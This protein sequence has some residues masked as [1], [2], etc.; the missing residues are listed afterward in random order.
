M[1]N[2]LLLFGLLVIHFQ[3]AN[4]QQISEQLA[5]TIAKNV[6][7]EVSL[8]N[9]VTD[10]VFFDDIVKSTDSK[11][12]PAIFIFNEKDGGFVIVSADKRAYPILA[13]STSSFVQNDT[14]EWSPSFRAWLKM[15]SLQIDAM[16]RENYKVEESNS[17]LWLQLE[18]GKSIFTKSSK[19]VSPLLV[20]T[21]NQGC[22]YNAL[23]P[24]ASGGPCGR[25]Y[26]GC[27]ATAM[28]QVM[29]HM[30]HPSTGIG[31]QCYTTSNY[32]ELC[33]NFADGTY[34]YALMTNG[35]GNSHV[36]KLMYHCGVS[37]YM[38]YSPSGSGAYSHSV[39]N[40][41]K[42]FFD[43][44]NALLV[45]KGN[46]TE[47]NWTRIIRNEIDNSRPIYYAGFGGSSGHAFV[48]DG[49]QNTTH[50]HINWGWGGA[51]NGYFY[52]SSLNPGGYSYTNGQQAIVGAIPTASFTNLNVSSA[53][54]LT[55]ATPVSGNISLGVDY[56]NYYKN[57]YPSAVGKELVYT[58]TT[59]LPGRIR[60]KVSNNVGG[61]VNV[62]LLSHPHQDSLIASGLN[63]VIVDN[64]IAKT[65]Y[66][67]VEGSNGTQPTF[68]IEVI[69]P[70]IDADL[71][72]TNSN[73]APQFIESF[74]GNVMF[75]STLKNIGN[76]NAGSCS[77]KY[78]LSDDLTLDGSDTFLGSDI[79]PAIPIGA[80]Q[81]IATNL[82]MPGGLVSGSYN[83][84]F[85]ADNENVVVESDDDNFAFAYVQVP[86]TGIMSC[87]ASVNL[88][89]GV[90]H[91]GNTQADGNS[92]I[93]QYWSASDMTGP[94][95]I[96]SFTPLFDGFTKVTFSEKNAGTINAIVLPICN[97]NTYLT[98]IWFSN[99]T[100]TIGYAE[101]YATAGTEY[102]IVVDGYKGEF[103]NYALKV[104]YPKECP[105]V[106]LQISG[107]T[108]LCDGQS[109]PSMWTAWGGSNYQWY[110]NGL[111]IPTETSSWF[112]P[113]T[114]GSYHIEITENGC[115]GS[116]DTI[117]VEMSFQPDTAQITTTDN[118]EFCIGGSA[119]LSL[120]N[121]VS[122]P[123][124]WAINGTLIPG[125]T[126]ENYVASQ[127]GNYTLATTNG[128]CTVQS[129]NSIE[130][131]T[132]QLPSNIGEKLP[133]PSENIK[134]Y[135]TFEKDNSDYSG[136]NFTFSCWNFQPT[137]DRFNNFWQARYFTNENVFGY[138]P[139]YHTIPNEFTLTLWFK[140]SSTS[141]GVIA[142]FVN[143]PWNASQME[144]MLYMSNNGKLHFYITNAGTPAELVSTFSYNDNQWHSVTIQFN[145]Q[146]KMTI[147]NGDEL[148]ENLN[149]ITKLNVTG[150]WV[151]AGPN[152]PAN[153]VDMPSSKYFDGSI[154]DML[155]VYETNN[156]IDKYNYSLPKLGIQILSNEINCNSALLE[157]EIENSELDTQYRIWNE[158]NAEWH[159][160]A[161]SGN[162]GNITIT[163]NSS[164]N[165]TT[166]FK[167]LAKN[168]ITNCEV[169]LD[170]TITITVNQPTAITTQPLAQAICEGDSYTFSILAEGSNLMYQW[171]KG[172][173]NI[174]TNSPS[175]I[176][177]NASLTDAGNYTCTV[178]GSCGEETSQIAE[179][180]VTTST[181]IMSE[182]IG[183]II[184]VGTNFVLSVSVSGHN[185][186][187]QWKKGTDNV[188]EN[189]DSYSITNAQLSD[190]GTYSC[191]IT[192]TCGTLI[193][194]DME[195]NVIQTTL[196]NEQPAG[197]SICEGESHTFTIDA[198]GSNLAFQ[199]KKGT[200]NIGTNSPSLTILNA[201][202]S[203][204][205]D[206]ECTVSGLCG[207][208]T[209][210]IA[211]LV[212]NQQP[213]ANFSF[214]IAN[215]QTTFTNTSQNATSY[216]WDFGDESGTST[217]EN[218]TY[219]YTSNGNFEVILTA[220][221]GT[222]NDLYSQTINVITDIETVNNANLT[223]FPN[224]TSG[225]LTLISNDLNINMVDIIDVTGKVISSQQK[226]LNTEFN[227]DLSNYP[228]GVY[229][230]RIRGE[231]LV[232]HHK[233]IK[234]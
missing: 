183:D 153:V 124:N 217:F 185:L 211:T 43:Y 100:D 3:I 127:A 84:I 177:S 110:Q 32:G 45:G 130:L 77:I 189:S 114:A 53:E 213:I 108:K 173:E 142:G 115:T 203:N 234:N 146:M 174:G 166:N 88:L 15:Y 171:K 188:G 138:C 208:E 197:S 225:K 17:K 175:L 55:C 167:V 41:W 120:A 162:Y 42:K 78:Y 12:N 218:P 94:E 92:N 123:I 165:Q 159:S 104:D 155:C 13:Y 149:A 57:N 25:V 8:K 158:T 86:T 139:D 132:K 212:V 5:A 151:F 219:T 223:I 21:W 170:T 134:F 150:Y 31:S 1:K 136:N 148:L 2:L 230:L 40:A 156:F 99:L 72:F 196:I 95:V 93:T 63:G 179:L 71:I 48:F 209:S 143:N 69:C 38:N 109:F 207:E 199:W 201:E 145:G 226:T 187:Y 210:Q 7:T 97:E 61:D 49:Y 82:S 193:S 74:L 221:N 119:M 128:S 204:A 220:S 111:A 50:F 91:Y 76:T 229:I 222:C 26:T 117:E 191:T 182:S 11:G 24:V 105:I 52:V 14:S 64:T 30:E 125:A 36:A 22:G 89:D 224:P 70:T 126:A 118:L 75:T 4:G 90:W 205:G 133:I 23:C 68:D 67:A 58:F 16:R 101:F 122:Y 202:V 56:I 18:T 60:L 200:E 121:T 176:I 152:L 140:T 172:S 169:F 216:N 51:Y 164:I 192:G 131:K 194:S 232:L 227:L 112:S 66:A 34:N 215:M 107:N 233:V 195:I 37:V 35:S 6:F 80:T 154:D 116:S 54:S 160:N 96:H 9:S 113:I 73:V 106:N 59:S 81:N 103:G 83:V 28:A 161:V 184:C 198:I 178:T 29:R 186:S 190:A 98:N 10:I 157:I 228:S 129:E 27:V 144:S 135:Y 168:T 206:Y 163:G 79:I 65:Y 19:D 20:T 33:A 102:F 47:S 181:F 85:V 39:V 62:F 44:K 214:E 46:Y 141:G 180:E 87:T 147:N 137:N 231:K